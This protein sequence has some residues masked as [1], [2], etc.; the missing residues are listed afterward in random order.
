MVAYYHELTEVRNIS[1]LDPRLSNLIVWSPV[2]FAD[3]H[4]SGVPYHSETT[5]SCFPV[6]SGRLANIVL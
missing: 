1:P 6:L 4:R 5:V 2:V 3:I